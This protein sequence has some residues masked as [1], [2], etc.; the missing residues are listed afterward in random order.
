MARS[1][2]LCSLRR[3]PEGHLGIRG[4]LAALPSAGGLSGRAIRKKTWTFCKAEL[5]G[6][7][8]PAQPP[9]WTRGLAGGEWTRCRSGRTWR[10]R[11]VGRQCENRDK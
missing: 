8:R 10:R 2:Y 7:D 5:K 6:G 3:R 9:Q 4:E 11:R 1:L